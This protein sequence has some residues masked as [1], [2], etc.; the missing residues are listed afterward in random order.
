MEI[1]R[2]LSKHSI[3]ADFVAL[4]Q[5]TMDEQIVV[6][7][8]DPSR[9]LYLRPSQMPFCAVQFFINRSLN[10]LYT[11]LDMAGA[12]YTSVGT[13]VHEVMQ[14]FLCRSGRLLADYHCRECDTWHRMSYRHE[15]CGFPTQ[16][17]EARIDYRGIKGHIDAVYK[18]KQGRLW[19]L[20]FKTTSIA[21]AASK[22]KN[23]GIVYIEQIETYA[24]LFELQYGL[25]I[26]GIMDAF[27]MRDN[28]KKDP[29][30]WARPLTDLMRKQVKKR[31]AGYRKAHAA[32]IE[33]S[34]LK[35]ALGL[36]RFG[37]CKN[38]DCRWCAKSDST[39]KSAIV[40]AHK[41]GVS[42]KRLPIREMA[43]RE[44]AR[45]ARF[46]KGLRKAA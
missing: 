22:K 3:S 16:Y 15:C 8:S 25:K 17:H 19:I 36:R 42:M 38:P 28:P 34:T 35:E 1:L 2:P 18:D 7:K 37:R 5:K 39:L 21:G 30:V 11:N 4:Y 10:G 14:N 41:T 45:R 33:A 46:N 31:L 27:I 29:A 20:D 6:E 24:V 40:H 23:P 43:E 44:I 9:V 26:E 32:A 13:T 12:Y